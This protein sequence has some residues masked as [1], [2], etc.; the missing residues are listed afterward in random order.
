MV[1]FLDTQHR[2][3]ASE[4][5]FQ[6]TLSQTSVYPREVVK[7]ALSHNAAAVILAHNHPSGVTEPSQADRL[8]TG[9]LKQALALV[10]VSVL[11]H[12]VVAAGQTL[13]FAERGLL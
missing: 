11:D 8:L 5:L 7:R 1:L 4:E 10:D 2:V 9:A 13:S 3:I 6:G 12:F